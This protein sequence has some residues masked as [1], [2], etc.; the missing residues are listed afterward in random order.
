M[1]HKIKARPWFD[2]YEQVKQISEVTPRGYAI[3][4]DWNCQLNQP[5]NAIPIL[6]ELSREERVG[7]FED[8]ISRVDIVGQRAV[9]R[10]SLSSSCNA[11][12]RRSLCRA[13][14]RECRRW[15]CG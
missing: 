14:A 7:L 4:I 2:I 13:D 5:A 6:E 11:L 1:A 15:I 8:P 9:K 3:D 10:T 12:R